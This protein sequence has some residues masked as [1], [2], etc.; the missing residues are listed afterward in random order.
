MEK[1]PA[2]QTFPEVSETQLNESL[3]QDFQTLSQA[4]FFTELVPDLSEVDESEVWLCG[5]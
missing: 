2:N 4:S 1:N 3:R 5:M